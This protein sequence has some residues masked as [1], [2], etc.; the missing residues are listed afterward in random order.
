MKLSTKRGFISEQSEERSPKG[1][2][3]IELLV[4]I[5]I[6]L[7]LAGA[8]ML[9]INPVATM[10]KGRDATRLSDVT[11]VRDAINMKLAEGVIPAD[12]TMRNSVSNARNC[13]GATTTLPSTTDWINVNVCDYVGTLPIDPSNNAT[14][15]Y[16]YAVS[17]E[18]YELRVKLEYSGNATKMANDGGSNSDWYEVGTNLFIL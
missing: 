11:V 4:V 17:G 6:I 5:T 15:Q 3:L 18:R 14:Y 8:V 7:I 10:Q 16:Q 13:T 9:A 2:T 12:T 1:F